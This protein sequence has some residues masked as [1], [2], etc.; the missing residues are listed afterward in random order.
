VVA[1]LLTP[2]D[3]ARHLKVAVETV[4]GWLRRGELP[5]RKLGKS[6]LW[7]VDAADVEAFAPPPMAPRHRRRGRSTADVER[8]LRK[9]GV[10]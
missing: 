2:E 9:M 5:G 10:A 3:V 4:H 8:R 1:E 7:R 6:R